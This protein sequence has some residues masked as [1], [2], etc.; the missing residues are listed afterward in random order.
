ME[1]LMKRRLARALTA[2]G[3]SAVLAIF[4]VPA[5]AAGSAPIAHP[6]S[7]ES[8]IV[9]PAGYLCLQETNGTV[10]LAISGQSITFNP[11]L[12]VDLIENE[13][14]I[15]YCVEIGLV[16]YVPVL[17]GGV[18]SG[19]RTVYAVQPGPVCYG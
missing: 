16:I 14:S 10:V 3:V 7:T 5:Y 19:T 4:A 9:C 15:P 2:A 12:R 8:A 18:V 1:A 13:T 17:S 11:P 6:A